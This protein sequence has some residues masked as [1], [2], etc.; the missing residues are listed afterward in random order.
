MSIGRDGSKA[1]ES[2]VSFN[3]LARFAAAI[4]RLAID[5]LDWLDKAERTQVTRERRAISRCWRFVV[6]SQQRFSLRE[7]GNGSR[8]EAWVARAMFFAARVR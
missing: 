5:S 6:Y 8:R 1:G 2:L 3:Y 4:D 7:E